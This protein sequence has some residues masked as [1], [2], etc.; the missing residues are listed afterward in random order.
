MIH[1][2]V[3]WIGKIHRE[4]ANLVHD[5][6]GHQIDHHCCYTTPLTRRMHPSQKSGFLFIKM[7]ERLAKR[8]KINEN[9]NL[10]IIWTWNRCN[11]RLTN[12]ILL[13]GDVDVAKES[14]CV[15]NCC[16]LSS[17]S[18]SKPSHVSFGISSW[19]TSTNSIFSPGKRNWKKIKY[20]E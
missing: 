9:L 12:S 6:L 5:N 4:T 10:F 19:F 7:S 1:L 18:D 20:G 8:G 3:G 16:E 13:E 17:K 11:I 2:P 15:C 14:S